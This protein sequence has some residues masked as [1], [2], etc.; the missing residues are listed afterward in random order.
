MYIVV[1]GGGKVGYYLLK[2]LWERKHTLVLIEEREP[3]C[4]RIANELGIEVVQGDGTNVKILEDAG[5]AKADVVVI[6]T[7]KDEDNLVAALLVQNN[8]DVARV[9]ARVNN[10]RNEQIFR[11]LGVKLTVSATAVIADLIE[12]EVDLEGMITLLTIYRGLLALFEGVL[13]KA[14]PVI[15]KPIRDIAKDLPP[16]CILVSVLR[17]DEVVF[18]RG[19]TVLHE[20]DVVLALTRTDQKKLLEKQLLGAL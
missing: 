9:I 3:I 20:G 16:D 14:S 7:G 17:G 18:P 11:A 1:I 19:D 15:G 13:G 4:Q 8:F 2:T 12:Q 5:V 6:V 10:P